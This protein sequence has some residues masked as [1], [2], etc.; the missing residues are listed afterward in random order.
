MGVMNS[1]H[2]KTHSYP[3]PSGSV[4]TLFLSHTHSVLFCCFTE[5]TAE[6]RSLPGDLHSVIFSKY[7]SQRMIRRGIWFLR[8]LIFKNMEKMYFA[9]YNCKGMDTG[10][11][12]KPSDIFMHTSKRD[13]SQECLKLKIKRLI[14]FIKVLAGVQH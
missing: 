13:Y 12:D 11:A 8:G 14:Y 5:I 6:N 7:F 4:R 3:S 2:R 1:F 9:C 10:F